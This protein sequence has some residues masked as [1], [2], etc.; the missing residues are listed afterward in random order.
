MTDDILRPFPHAIGPEKSLLSSMLQDPVEF[1]GI[2]IE[3]GL[4]T[5]HF[6]LPAHSKLFGIMLEFFQAGREIEFV[7]LTQTLLDRGQLEAIGGPGAMTDIYTYAP[8]PGQFRQH[9]ETIKGKFVGRKLINLG[10]TV[11]ESVYDSPESPAEALADASRLLCEAESIWSGSTVILT[12]KELLRAQAE[13]YERRIRGE[14]DSIGLPTYPALDHH[15]RGLH[16]GRLYVIGAYPG[17]GKSTMS[18]EIVSSLVLAGTSCAYVPLEGNEHDAMTRMVIQSAGVH[19]S[20]YTD[21][22]KYAQANQGNE[23]TKL[24]MNK[25]KRAFAEL[26]KAPLQI[27]RP[28][29]PTITHIVA[30]IRRLHREDGIKI[31]VVDYAQRIKATGKHEGGDGAAKECSNALQDLAG[32]LNIAIIVPSQLTEDGDT[33]HGKVWGEDADVVLRIVQDRNKESE[34]YKQH[35]FMMIDKDRQ[36][37]SAGNRVPLI[38]DPERIK[39]I[40]GDDTTATMK[41]PK[42]NR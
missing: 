17:G 8:N 42:F 25:I 3:E 38:F 31:V 19:A 18:S 27:R 33:K 28:K 1:I 9:C 22:K 21:P 41:K 35:R 29:T 6:Y 26:S 36:N 7:S 15:I 10:H 23:I 24:V 11:T 20:A 32:E 4:T 12:R 30:L 40:E 37:G 16:G 13:G 2:A 39:F 5:D 14:V 34:T